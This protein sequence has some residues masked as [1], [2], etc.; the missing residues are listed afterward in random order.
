MRWLLH[1]LD[2]GLAPAGAALAMPARSTARAPAGRASGPAA[3]RVARDARPIRE[4]T[5]QINA[6]KGELA[7]LVRRHAAALLDVPG[8]GPFIA[9]RMVAEVAD[10]DRFRSDA[11]LALYA[12]VAPLD[13]SSGRQHRHRLNRTG[14]RQLNPRCT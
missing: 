7:A 11:Q 8:C 4:L 10:V 1:D 9:A 13:A 5:M 12:G 14:N 6:L 2:P 3:V